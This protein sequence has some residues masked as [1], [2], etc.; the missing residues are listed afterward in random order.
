[1]REGG[2]HGF[3]GT[4]PNPSPHFFPIKNKNDV[5][6]FHLDREESIQISCLSGEI[7]IGGGFGPCFGGTCPK[8]S[9]PNFFLYGKNN[10]TAMHIA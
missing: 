2:E 4:C 7:A 3:G 10:T 8:T 5:K 9:P 1:M 6:S